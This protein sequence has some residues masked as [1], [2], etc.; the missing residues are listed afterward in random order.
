[1]STILCQ[2]RTI[3]QSA[4]ARTNAERRKAKHVANEVVVDDRVKATLVEQIDHRF[5][6]LR[7]LVAVQHH[8]FEFHTISNCHRH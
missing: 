7:E 8:K 4:T 1:M 3:I 2:L 5:A 6:G